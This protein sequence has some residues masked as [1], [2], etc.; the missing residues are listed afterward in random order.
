MEHVLKS[1]SFEC[2][3]RTL[4]IILIAVE[5]Y[6]CKPSIRH[7]SFKGLNLQVEWSPAKLCL[8][9]TCAG[10]C[11]AAVIALVPCIVDGCPFSRESSS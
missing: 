10:C 6:D 2:R 8:C 5:L 3:D 7:G 11:S 9:T 4:F 1:I